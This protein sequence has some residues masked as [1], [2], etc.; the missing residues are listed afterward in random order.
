M[1]IK[2]VI[3]GGKLK[4]SYMSSWNN[5]LQL[6]VEGGHEINLKI[7]EEELRD[8][9]KSLN[10]RIAEIDN[11]RAEAIAEAKEVAA[12]EAAAQADEEESNG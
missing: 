9:T 4:G 11:E 10:E 6:T 5:Q 3:D 12:L 2:Q 8:L 1:E 7:P